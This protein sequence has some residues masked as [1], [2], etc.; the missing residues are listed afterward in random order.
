M[1]VYSTEEQT[2]SAFGYTE[3]TYDQGTAGYSWDILFSL[4]PLQYHISLD[5]RS[6]VHEKTQQK[7]WGDF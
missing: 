5:L 3:Y 1:E 4:E 7:S 2:L 6:L